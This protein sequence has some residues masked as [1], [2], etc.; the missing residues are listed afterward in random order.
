MGGSSSWALV[1]GKSGVLCQKK[2]VA[3]WFRDE[4]VPS[5]IRWGKLVAASRDGRLPYYGLFTLFTRYI[6]PNQDL[7]V[8]VL[9]SRMKTLKL[10][11]L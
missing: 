7:V 6:H 10:C 4:K 9:H 8:P 2:G 1:I 3:N 11:P 5:F